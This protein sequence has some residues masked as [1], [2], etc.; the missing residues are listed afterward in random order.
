VVR[1]VQLKSRDCKRPLPPVS[2]LHTHT[3]IQTESSLLQRSV[4]K[5]DCMPKR[6]CNDDMVWLILRCKTQTWK[7][8]DGCLLP[9]KIIVICSASKVTTC[10]SVYQPCQV[11]LNSMLC[12][13]GDNTLIIYQSCHT[14]VK[15]DD[16][17]YMRYYQL[18]PMHC[19]GFFWEYDCHLHWYYQ[20]QLMHSQLLT[21]KWAISGKMRWQSLSHT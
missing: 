11:V 12:Q 15:Q 10:S 16:S 20:L 2:Q 5:E 7:F 14:I 17:H 6:F 19:P 8:M 4:A 1:A 9:G 3:E 21:K 13:Q 18:Q